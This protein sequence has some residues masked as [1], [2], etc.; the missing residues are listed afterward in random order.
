MSTPI[1]GGPAEKAGLKKGDVIL[2]VGS[3]DVTDLEAAVKAVRL[4]RPGD[5]LEFH[6]RRDGK[7]M[8][9]AVA[10]GVF[11]FHWAAGLE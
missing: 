2:K 7:E 6:I 9:I 1:K 4:A 5:K 8:T 11:P 3:V 10:V